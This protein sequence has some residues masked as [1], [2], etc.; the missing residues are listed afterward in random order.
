MS[1]RDE[2]IETVNKLFIYTD[3]RDWDRLISEV[4]T[5]RVFLDMSS[6]GG[7][8]AEINAEEICKMWEEGFRGLDAVNHL[9]GNYLVDTDRNGAAVYCYATATHYRKDAKHGST[10]EFVGTYDLHLELV[11][12]GWKIDRMK[13]TL[14]YVDGNP[15]LT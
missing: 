7:E 9:A 10:R 12:A 14:K 13:Y 2:I 3:N 5:P 15:D 8:A 1:V 11:A 4:F 6:M